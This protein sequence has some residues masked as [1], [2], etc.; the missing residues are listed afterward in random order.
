MSIRDI[1]E[2]QQ[3]ENRELFEHF[4]TG[5]A[6]PSEE[7]E[8]FQLVCDLSERYQKVFK[9]RDVLKEFQFT[10]FEAKR[11]DSEWHR[12]IKRQV[13]EEPEGT[14][15]PG[16]AAP[17]IA[18]K[19]KEIGTGAT[20]AMFAEIQE[21]GN[22]LVLQ[23]AA[24]AAVRGENLKDYIIKCIELR[25]TIGDQVEAIQQEN[26]LLKSLCSMFAQALKPNFKQLAATRMYL[27]WT[28]GLMQLQALGIELSQT[29]IDEVTSKI[30]QAMGIQIL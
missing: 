20:K 30:E 9:I 7:V 16:P 2:L 18:T 21:I 25:E 23:Y 27:D 4:R 6:G 3:A 14:P 22:L 19:S 15:P 8:L 17:L 5:I 13:K 26:Q 1:A 10:A 24:K 28:T 29:Y 12:W 11:F